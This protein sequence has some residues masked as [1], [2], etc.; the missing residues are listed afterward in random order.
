[1]KK[2][3]EIKKIHVLI[4]LSIKCFYLIMAL[5]FKDYLFKKNN[6]YLKKMFK[7]YLF[8]KKTTTL[9]S[10]ERKCYIC[11]KVI[12]YLTFYAITILTL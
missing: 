10:K 3:N 8:K 1:M 11:L 7:D 4:N 9:K 6:I 5:M 12:L 2:R